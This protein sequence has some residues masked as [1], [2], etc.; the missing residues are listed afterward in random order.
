MRV[1]FRSFWGVDES[2]GCSWFREVQKG[3]GRSRP[4]A[5]EATGR[6]LWELFGA[7]PAFDVFWRALRDDLQARRPVSDLRLV[8]NSPEGGRFRWRINGKPYY[9]RT[10]RFRGYRGVAEDESA[11]VEARRRAEAAEER[12][13]DAIESI[14]GGFG[15][16]DAEDRLVLCNE[17]YRWRGFGDQLC[18][19]SGV[20]SDARRVGKEG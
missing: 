15:L 14:S 9:D 4:T 16:F 13:S 5:A 8:Y 7:N 18:P 11:E 10:G 19:A 20:R 17:T 1:L 6:T 12:L 2:L 3:P